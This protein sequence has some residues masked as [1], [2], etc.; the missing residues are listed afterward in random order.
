MDWIV[1]DLDSNWLLELVKAVMKLRVP[2]SE[3][4]YLNG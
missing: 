2:E 3:V 4:N 1:V